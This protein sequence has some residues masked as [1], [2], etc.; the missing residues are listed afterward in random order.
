MTTGNNKGTA[1]RAWVA[2]RIVDILRSGG[3]DAYYDGGRVH[4]GSDVIDV[5]SLLPHLARSDRSTWAD[6]IN[7]YASGV[8]QNLAARGNQA[9]SPLGQLVV[10]DVA[11]QRSRRPSRAGVLSAPSLS[12]ALGMKPRPVQAMTS[13]MLDLR[14]QKPTPVAGEIPAAAPVQAHT[15]TAAPVII[16]DPA[17]AP[18]QHPLEQLEQALESL[19]V[20]VVSKDMTKGIPTEAIGPSAVPGTVT[21][22]SLG[23]DEWVTNDRLGRW[24]IDRSIA[25]GMAE[26]RIRDVCRPNVDLVLVDASSR[27]FVLESELPEIGAALAFLE[28]HVPLRSDETALVATG[29]EHVA[30]VSLGDNPTKAALAALVDGA[31]DEH[32]KRPG[33]LRPALYRRTADGR[34]SLLADDLDTAAGRLAVRALVQTSEAVLA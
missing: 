12:A 20:R 29:G 6:A 2:M 9:S 5:E 15:P 30:I 19:S 1:D 32:A 31:V 7:Q 34:I 13:G 18:T 21:A 33:R 14:S 28:L 4:T 11:E 16:T 10:E 8:A 27:V 3:L 22:L 17:P 25:E 23:A 24:C 26:A